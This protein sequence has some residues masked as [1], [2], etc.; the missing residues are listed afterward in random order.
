MTDATVPDSIRRLWHL[1]ADLP[2]RGRKSVLDT[3]TV[4]ETAVELAD[5]GGLEAATLPRVAERL[6]VTAMSLYRHV[7]SKHEL[8]ELMMDG[9]TSPP[10]DPPE[11][12]GWREGLWGWA[13][14]MATLYERRAWLPRVPIFRP[15]AGP[16]QIA[17]LERGFGHLASTG[18][19]WDEKVTVMTL[20]SGHVRH[21]AL[22]HHELREGR[23]PN[24]T[25][26]ESE[27]EYGRAL[28][29]LIDPALYPQTA[30][31]LETGLF[32]GSPTDPADDIPL[33]HDFADGLEL[34]L[35]GLAVRVSDAGR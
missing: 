19:E 9:A 7:G 5:A 25:Q 14:E 12:S 3:R 28:T 30:A 24:R 33:G 20:L 32:G 13:L 6:G 11:G 26:P 15:P 35:D 23:A 1:P 8:L 31:M 21:Y 34:I 18:L 10:P 22:L 17:W 2:R 16:N 27:E 29:E 4:V